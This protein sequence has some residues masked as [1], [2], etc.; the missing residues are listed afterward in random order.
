MYFGADNN[1]P[2]WGEIKYDDHAPPS[3]LTFA[4]WC[5]ANVPRLCV[6]LREAAEEIREADETTGSIMREKNVYRRCADAAEER[7]KDAES[8]CQAQQSA[9]QNEAAKCREY[10]EALA[11]QVERAKA[12]EEKLATAQRAL[13]AIVTAAQKALD[14]IVI[15]PLRTRE[16]NSLIEEMS[17]RARRVLEE[18]E[19]EETT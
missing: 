11:G 18:T 1:G 7:A 8:R 14:A 6:A 19:V 9:T 13:N 15:A 17:T 2:S 10:Q 12:A 16:V 4:V 3:V 5:R